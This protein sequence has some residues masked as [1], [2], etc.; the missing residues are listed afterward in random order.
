MASGGHLTG[1]PNISFLGDNTMKIEMHETTMMD[2]DTVIDVDI[3]ANTRNGVIPRCILTFNDPERAMVFVNRLHNLLDEFDQPCLI[4][5]KQMNDDT[6]LERMFDLHHCY[7]RNC[8]YLDRSPGSDWVT[9]K[10]RD[11]PTVFEICSPEHCPKKG[12]WLCYI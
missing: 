9:C 7:K 11:N 4:V 2:G 5:S 6:W 3:M 1:L 8:V 12:E 10:H